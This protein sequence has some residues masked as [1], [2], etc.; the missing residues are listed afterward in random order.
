MLGKD[1]GLLRR[2]KR[3]RRITTW[4]GLCANG[5]GEESLEKEEKGGPRKGCCEFSR[6][7]VSK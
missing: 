5:D 4:A 3:T 2:F 1:V 7:A 6:R